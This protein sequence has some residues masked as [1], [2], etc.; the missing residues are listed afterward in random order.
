M[1]GDIASMETASSLTDINNAIMSKAFTLNDV[2]EN[3]RH[4]MGS[5]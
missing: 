5:L 2:R 3:I 4:V 1:T